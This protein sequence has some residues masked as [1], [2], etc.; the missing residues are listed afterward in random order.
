MTSNLFPRS[1]R[2]V[3]ITNGVNYIDLTKMHTLRADY[4]VQEQHT[5]VNTRDFSQ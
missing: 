5:Q 3:A 1:I 2:Q 4:V